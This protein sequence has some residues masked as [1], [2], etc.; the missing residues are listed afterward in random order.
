MKMRGPDAGGPPEGTPELHLG[1]PDGIDVQLQD[2]RYC[3]GTDPLGNV[4]KP[5]E[6]T[7]AKGLLAIRDLSHFTL[8]V[9]DRRRST[10]SGRIQRWNTGALLHR[11]GRPIDADSGR[12]LLRWVRVPGRSLRLNYESNN[13]RSS[14][15]KLPTRR[16]SS[17]MIASASARFDFCSSSTFS[18]TVSRAISL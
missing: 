4:C 6:P 16:L 14:R 12:D 17:P 10:A 11:P 5:F 3:G 1:D 18:S 2:V 7:P 15:F 9:S 13:S 8:G